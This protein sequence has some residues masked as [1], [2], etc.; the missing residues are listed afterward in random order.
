MIHTYVYPAAAV[1]DGNANSKVIVSWPS[2]VEPIVADA[3]PED[4]NN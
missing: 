1:I 2:W 4:E 3:S